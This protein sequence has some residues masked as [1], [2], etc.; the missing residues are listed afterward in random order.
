MAL[1]VGVWAGRAGALVIAVLLAGCYRDFGPVEVVPV[2]DVP[3]TTINAPIQA[4]DRI[5]VI[6]YGEANLTGIYDVSPAGTLSLPLIGQVRAAGRNPASLEREITGRYKGKYLEEPKITVSVV[7]FRPFYVAGEA[8]HPGQYPYYGGLNVLTAITTAGGL[9]YRA[10]R[11][12]VLIQ[13]AGDAVWQEYP[14]LATVPV[15][16]GDLIRVPERF[17]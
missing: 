7:V 11:S 2:P 10:S 6:V 15:Y 9:T 8:E 14:M 16:P 1:N 5:N 3:A 13:R 4:G 12:T 17:F